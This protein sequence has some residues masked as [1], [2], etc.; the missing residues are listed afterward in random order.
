MI[1]PTVSNCNY[2]LTEFYK[3][4]DN[5]SA[6][7]D[8][9]I[10]RGDDNLSTKLESDYHDICDIIDTFVEFRRHNDCLLEGDPGY[11]PV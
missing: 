4:R 8:R 3:K 5:I 11:G 2:Y 7:I 6:S 1:Q 9:A 10:M